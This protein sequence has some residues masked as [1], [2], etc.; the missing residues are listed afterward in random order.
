MKLVILDREGVVNRT[1]E[2]Y[3]LKPEQ[4]EVLP[5]SLDAIAR[6]HHSGYR[7]AVATNQAALSRGL[8]DMAMLNTIHLRM[9]RQVDAAGGAIDAIAI[10]PHNPEQNCNCRKPKP[11]ML[12]ELIERFGANAADT[13]MVGDTPA[14]IQAGLAAGCRTWLVRTGHGQ[15][16]IDAG[17][18]PEAVEVCDDLAAVVRVLL[19]LPPPDHSPA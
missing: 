10:C 9:C 5:G 6:L 15:A 3:V 11:G 1:V 2:G 18:V 12:L 8:F 14:D 4:W 7:I 17:Q 13:I 16:M 19:S